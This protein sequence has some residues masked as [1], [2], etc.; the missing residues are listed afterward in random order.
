MRRRT[1]ITIETSRRLIVRRI[2]RGV[3][4][5]C[6]GCLRQVEMI[7]PNEAA[8][9]LNVSSRAIYRWIE[10]GRLHFI[11][12]GTELFVCAESL[13]P[14]TTEPGAELSIVS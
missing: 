9:V 6:D 5:W 13:P 4:G 1:E 14:S 7:T 3:T 12:C 10:N 2:S 11:E 8:A